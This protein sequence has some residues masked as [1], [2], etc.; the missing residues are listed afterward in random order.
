[1]TTDGVALG[2][3]VLDAANAALGELGWFYLSDDGKK[4]LLFARGQSGITVIIR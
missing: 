1:M 2:S 3:G 4:L